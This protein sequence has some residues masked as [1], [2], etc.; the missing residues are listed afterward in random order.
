MSDMDK[1]SRSQDSA[2]INFRHNSGVVS[3]SGELNFVLNKAVLIW[4][5]FL[6]KYVFL[7]FHFLFAV[8]IND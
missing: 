3:S 5:Q 4:F 2:R 8:S 1:F 7:L 6:H